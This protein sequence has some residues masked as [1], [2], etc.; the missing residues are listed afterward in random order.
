[1]NK[2]FTKADLKSGDIITFREG[3]YGMY[4]DTFDAVMFLENDGSYLPL[5]DII[6]ITF[7]DKYGESQWDIIK[8]QRPEKTNGIVPYHWLEGKVMWEEKPPI[9]EMTLE[10]VCKALG[11]E[12][13]IVKSK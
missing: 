2:V 8:I 9:E 6:N 4:I 11:K 5:T 12:I 7:K 3:S 10:E 1:M 13:K